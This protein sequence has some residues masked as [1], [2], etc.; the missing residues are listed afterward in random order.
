MSGRGTVVE[1]GYP[2]SSDF[3]VHSVRDFAVDEEDHTILSS[4]IFNVLTVVSMK[5][6]R[7]LWQLSGVS[8]NWWLL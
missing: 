5:D 7:E 6:N 4:Y 8:R 1:G 3:G 2:A